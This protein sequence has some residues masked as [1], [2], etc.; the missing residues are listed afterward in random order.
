MRDG[1]IGGTIDARAAPDAY[2]HAGELNRSNVPLGVGVGWDT[3][4]VDGMRWEREK[5][6]M[7]CTTIGKR[8][9]IN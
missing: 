7:R 8:V 4:F 1:S 2:G 6:P 5:R 9:K 3:V